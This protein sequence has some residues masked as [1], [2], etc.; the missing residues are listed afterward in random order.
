MQEKR[1]EQFSILIS[2]KNPK[3]QIASNLQKEPFLKL[4]QMTLSGTKWAGIKSN[5]RWA[6]VRFL[7]GT[8][9]LMTCHNPNHLSLSLFFSI[10][11]FLSWGQEV[12]FPGHFLGLSF[13]FPLKFLILQPLSFAYQVNNLLQ[14]I[15]TA[16]HL[17][18]HF[19]YGTLSC[20]VKFLPYLPFVH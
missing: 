20:Q 8:Q 13:I 17:Y 14:I 19:Q 5:S 9:G 1:K 4:N 16:Y 2:A 12:Y 10:M 7:A 3:L 11:H 6:R 15:I 18:L